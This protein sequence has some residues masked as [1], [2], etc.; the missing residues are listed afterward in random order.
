MLGVHR[1]TISHA[2]RALQR[3]DLIERGRCRVTI[4]DR[5]GLI[6]A[7]CG[8]YLLVRARIAHHLPKT[9]PPT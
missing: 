1:P 6:A 3:E 4:R 9:F 2:A 7:S 5:D 8:C